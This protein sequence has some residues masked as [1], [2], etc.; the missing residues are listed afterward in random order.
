MRRLLVAVLG[1]VVGYLIGATCGYWAILI[2]SSNTFDRSLEA[3]M[4][5]AFVL[6]PLGGLVGLVA[7]L[8]MSKRKGPD[9]SAP[10]P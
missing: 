7:A 4:T 6:G 10:G 9:A 1:A 5:S 3:T 2:L 8:A